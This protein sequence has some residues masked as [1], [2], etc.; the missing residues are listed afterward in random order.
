[1]AKP[2]NRRTILQV[3]GGALALPA[4]T[5]LAWALDYPTRP[6]RIIVAFAAGGTTDIVGRLIGHWLSERLGQQFNVE[7]RPGGSGNIGT[8]AVLRAPADG[9]TLLL[10]PP[11]AAVNTTLFEHLSFNFARDIAPVAGIIRVP[12]V[13]EVNLS[14]PARN[15]SEFIAYAKAN[16]G[17]INFASAGSGTPQHVFGELFKL[18][19]SVEMVHVP[20]RGNAPALTDLLGGRVQVMFDTMPNSIEYIKAGKVRPLAVTTAVRWE[21]LPDLPTVSE[22][23]PGFEGSS[24]YGMAAPK[25]TPSVIVNKLNQ[26]VNAALHD[27]QMKTRLADLGGTMLEG[28]PA[29]FGRLIDD[30]TEKW[31]KVVRAANI[32]PD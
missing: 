15:V 22:F 18:I 11:A 3:S 16:P 14:V 32:K 9:Y 21:G 6:V 27:P 23:V 26:E 31:G 12:G 10:V 4:V 24:W 13:M 29:D 2:L 20:Y 28:S 1:M 5:R 30:E 17:K 8:E 7:N 25:N 19:T